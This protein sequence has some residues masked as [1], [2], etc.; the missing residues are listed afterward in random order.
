MQLVCLDSL[1][2]LMFAQSGLHHG[3][4]PCLYRILLGKTFVQDSWVAR[5][6][7]GQQE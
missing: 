4:G 5:M 2:V 6:T 1:V 7:V 3:L